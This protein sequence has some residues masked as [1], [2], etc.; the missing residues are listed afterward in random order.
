MTPHL[1]NYFL[2]MLGTRRYTEPVPLAHRIDRDNDVAVRHAKAL[3]L[4]PARPTRR[5]RPINTL[6]CEGVEVGFY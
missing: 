6:R 4:A 2:S 5:A 1:E 3:E